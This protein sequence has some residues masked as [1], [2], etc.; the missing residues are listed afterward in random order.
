M[1]MAQR[2]LELHSGQLKLVL[3]PINESTDHELAAPIESFTVTLLTGL[4]LHERRRAS[5]GQCHLT[6]QTQ[7]YAQ[8]MAA[9]LEIRD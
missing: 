2:I 8:D 3:L 5:C 1:L 4:P 9:L 7:A 6:L